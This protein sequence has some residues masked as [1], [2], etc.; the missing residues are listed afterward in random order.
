MGVPSLRLGRSVSHHEMTIIGGGR[1]FKALGL[2]GSLHGHGLTRSGPVLCG[3]S[4]RWQAFTAIYTG[5]F[6]LFSDGEII[7]LC[8]GW[9]HPSAARGSLG[10]A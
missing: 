10:E 4:C 9:Q 5:Y 6:A 3:G 7:G 2:S 1:D 8:N